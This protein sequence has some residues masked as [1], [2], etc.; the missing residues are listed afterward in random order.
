MQGGSKDCTGRT[1]TAVA[2]KE[3][4]PWIHPVR[5]RGQDVPT[6][7]AAAWDS[8]GWDTIPAATLSAG[9]SLAEAWECARGAG[10]VCEAVEGCMRGGVKLL[11]YPH[12]SLPEPHKLPV[13]RGLFSTYCEN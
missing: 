4:M 13:F 1:S 12:F 6:V 5:H 2:H 10:I 9:Q 8:C 7:P 3:F 11:F